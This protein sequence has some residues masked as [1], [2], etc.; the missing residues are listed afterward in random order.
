MAIGILNVDRELWLYERLDSFQHDL[1]IM[2]HAMEVVV[3]FM[4]SRIS[5]PIADKFRGWW[6]PKFVVAR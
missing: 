2:S 6:G 1:L 3:Q 4:G 5:V